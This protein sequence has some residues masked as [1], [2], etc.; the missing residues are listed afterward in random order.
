[1]AIQVTNPLNKNTFLNK[2]ISA[3]GG[4]LGT[5][6]NKAKQNQQNQQPNQSVSGYKSPTTLSYQQPNIGG[7]SIPDYGIKG[8]QAKAPTDNIKMP[9]NII[10]PA[11]AKTTQST[12]QISQPINPENQQLQN[13]QTQLTQKQNEL[14][15]AQTAGYGEN[16]QIQYDANGK[17][18]PANTTNAPSTPTPASVTPQP[19]AANKGLYGQLIT[20][21][22]NAPQTNP[23]VLQARQNLQNLQ[24][25]MAQETANLEGGGIDLSLATG[26]QGILN[27]LFATKQ[28]AAQTA[29]SSA[30]TSQGLQQQALQG[31]AGLATPAQVPYNVQYVSPLTGEGIGGGATG[32]LVA[33][34]PS[35][36]Q[37]VA[38]G[39]MTP[40]QAN[41]YLGNTTGL[42]DQLRQEVLKINPNYNFTIGSASGQTQAQGQ[43]LQTAA[44]SANQALDSLQS[45]YNNLGALQQTNIP[46]LN[47]ISSSLSMASGLGREQSS[48]YQ[49]ALNEARAQIQ[50]V[51]A[52]LIGVDAA[53]SN[54]LSLLPENMI[55][56]EIPQK[57][58]AAK[59]YI[60]QRVSAFVQ[61]GQQQ[62]GQQTGQ[63]NS[64]YSY[65]NFWGQ[66]Q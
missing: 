18:I 22:A 7:I 52:P 49:G 24:N 57:I 55:P 5:A 66:S 4:F 19:Y 27:R 21:L 1:M 14:G 44:Q 45:A 38:S 58:S 11:Q 51:L 26:Q 35:L 43:Q 53:K 54:T 17:I 39:Q 9:T 40:D 61:S 13:L 12:P 65:N 60:Q 28:Q 25:Q 64:P 50:T 2:G 46:I 10:T 56:S 31:A 29:L 20:G 37:Q 48:A 32:G 63:T 6:W 62:G 23:D 15:Q 59:Q 16:Q 42:T 34:I 3:V 47:Q 36:A 30:L 41:S 33:S 8:T